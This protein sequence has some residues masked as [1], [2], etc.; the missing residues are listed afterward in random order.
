MK[1]L[2]ISILAISA[3]HSVSQA[4]CSSSTTDIAKCT[5]PSGDTVML[6]NRP[7]CG[8]DKYT[9]KSGSELTF[10]GVVDHQDSKVSTYRFS[11]VRVLISFEATSALE[12]AMYTPDKSVTRQARVLKVKKGSKQLESVGIATCVPGSL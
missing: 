1:K 11:D 8:Y 12:S 4:S 5:L 10:N 2:I 9:L 6:T 7:E 3:F